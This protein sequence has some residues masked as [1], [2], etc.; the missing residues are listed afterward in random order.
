MATQYDSFTE[1]RGNVHTRR[2]GIRLMVLRDKG[3]K[4]KNAQGSKQTLTRQLR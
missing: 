2:K 4:D 1:I 3:E